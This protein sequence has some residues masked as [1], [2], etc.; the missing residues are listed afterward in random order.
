MT[1]TLPISIEFEDEEGASFS[2][3][4][5]VNI[6]VLQETRVQVLSVDIPKSAAA[7]QPV[8]LSMEFANTGRIALNNVFV[9]IVGDFPKENAT[10]FVP[11]LEIGMSDFFQGMIIPSEE[12][13][14][15]GSL[16][17]TYLDALNQEVKIEHP[18]TMTVEPMMDMPVDMPLEPMPGFENPQAGLP[19]FMIAIIGGGVIILLIA[20]IFIIKKI[21]AKRQN[22]FFNEKA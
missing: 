12:G 2:V 14:I 17:L 19:W 13:T 7:G 21:R 6:P 10:Y 3:N 22:D 8:P 5:S 15:S 18:F 16:T 11:R 20:A 4:E 1:Y 9:E